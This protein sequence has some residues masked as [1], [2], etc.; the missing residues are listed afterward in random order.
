MA[1]NQGFKEKFWFIPVVIPFQLDDGSHLN[2]AG[3]VYQDM[4]FQE[5]NILTTESIITMVT[6]VARNGGTLVDNSVYEDKGLSFIKLCNELAHR[7]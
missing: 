5:N 7:K 6:M 3:R 1:N 4:S 2:Y